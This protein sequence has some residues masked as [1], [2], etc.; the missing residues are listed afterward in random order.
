MDE[1]VGCTQEFRSSLAEVSA[2][3]MEHEWDDLP[4]DMKKEGYTFLKTLYKI[5]TYFYANGMGT[6]FDYLKK[7]TCFEEEA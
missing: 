3:Y 7:G 2:K 1:F 4:S 5:H 6:R